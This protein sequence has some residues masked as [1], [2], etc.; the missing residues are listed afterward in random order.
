MFLVKIVMLGMMIY[1]IRASLTVKGIVVWY[2]SVCGEVV[3]D[4]L[5]HK[6][7]ERNKLK[8]SL[9]LSQLVVTLRFSCLFSLSN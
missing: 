1:L 3:L 4:P 2:V 7:A 8:L 6:R 9:H 5:I